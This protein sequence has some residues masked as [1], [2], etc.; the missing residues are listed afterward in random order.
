MK[1]RDYLSSPG[2][3]TAEQLRKEIGARSASQIHQWASQWK[4]RQPS[5]AYAR[6]LEAATDGLVT[7]RELRDDWQLI[8]PELGDSQAGALEQAHG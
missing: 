7:R 4:G 3:K 1:L 2:S 5:A 6:Q 8:W